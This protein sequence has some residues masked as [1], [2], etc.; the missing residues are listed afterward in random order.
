MKIN[1]LKTLIFFF[2]FLIIAIFYL[3]IVGLETE[4]FNQQI[5]DKVVQS[6]SELN[7]DLKKIKLTLNPL[8]LEINAKTIGAVIYYSNRP[9]ELEYI[10]TKISL[11]SFFKNK[12]VSSNFEIVTKSI[13]LKDLI[14]FARSITFRPELLV[15][16]TMIENGHI[17]LDINLNLD[18][19]GKIKKDY[20]VKGI[21]KNG[22][23]Q[24]LQ[25]LV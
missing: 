11:E 16:E 17:I 22:K 25:D 24:F 19:N 13:F 1:F 15:L 3:S 20:E 18:E 7:I 23:I 5:K 4:K 14:K 6:K 8:K 12:L 10:K 9:I 21:L 2:S